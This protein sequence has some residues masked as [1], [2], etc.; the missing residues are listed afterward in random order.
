MANPFT[1]VLR[2]KK[3]FKFGISR[4]HRRLLVGETYMPICGIDSYEDDIF[5][6]ITDI[7]EKNSNT[8]SGI[9]QKK[10]FGEFEE[11]NDTSTRVTYF[12]NGIAMC[13]YL[14]GTANPIGLPD[15]L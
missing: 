12:C 15:K 11:D 4:A 2:S 1:K 6:C 5:G 9:L 3:T 7:A 13:R 10:L 8:K 14:Q